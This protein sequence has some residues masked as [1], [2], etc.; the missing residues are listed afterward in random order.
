ML[1]NVAINSENIVVIYIKEA[2]KVVIALPDG[3]TNTVTVGKQVITDDKGNSPA[4]IFS[5]ADLTV[6][7]SD[8]LSVISAS[9]DGI[10]SRIGLK[11]TGGT[12]TATSVSDGITG[13]DCV[14]INGATI[15]VDAG[16]DGIRS[17]NDE[18]EDK[19][20]VIIYAC[21]ITI[22]TT[23]DDI[24][25]E[26]ILHIGGGTLDNIGRRLPGQKH[27]QRSDG[28]GKDVNLAISEDRSNSKQRGEHE[29]T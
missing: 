8:N 4:A 15:T 10:A 3:T 9:N 27:Q 17:T 16:K 21:K 14:C 2:K 19:G 1:E 18:D 26:S 13:K 11:F 20:N 24:Q 25:A 22:K 5:K 23:N 28:H 12:V 29:G 6:A 7:E